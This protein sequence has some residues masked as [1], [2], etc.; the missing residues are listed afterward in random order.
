MDYPIGSLMTLSYKGEEGDLDTLC[1]DLEDRYGFIKIKS[2]QNG[3][4]ERL[5]ECLKDSK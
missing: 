2:D 1:K 4:P 3:E 5:E